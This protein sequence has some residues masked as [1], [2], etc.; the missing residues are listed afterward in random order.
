MIF[1]RGI[2]ERVMPGAAAAALE[3]LFMSRRAWPIYRGEA[4]LPCLEGEVEVRFDRWGVPHVRAQSLADLMRAQGYLVAQE[5]MVQLEMLRRAARGTLAEIVGE[6]AAHHDLF[7]RT[8]GLT[9][10]ARSVAAKIPQRSLLCLRCYSEGVNAYLA[11]FAEG[12]AAS[13]AALL[14]KLLSPWT[15]EDSLLCHLLFAWNAEATWME[16]LVKGRAMRRL[17][18][19]ATLALYPPGPSGERGER[20]PDISGRDDLPPEGCERDFFSGDEDRPA[21]WTPA[22]QARAS[23]CNGIV[24][25]GSRTE[26]GSPLLANDLHLPHAEPTFFFLLHLSC[27]EVPFDAAG[28]ALPGVP[29]IYVGRNRRI[30]WGTVAMSCPAMDVCVERLD[31]KGKGLYLAEGIWKKLERRNE[32]IKVF[33]RRVHNATVELTERG[34]LVAVDGTIGISLRWIDHA[35]EGTDAVGSLLDLNMAEDWEGFRRAL[36]GY[37]GPAS[38]FLYADAEGR[39][40]Y[41]AAGTV[42]LREGYDGS[43][44]LPGWEG[45]Y[46]WNGRLPYDDM[47]YTPQVPGGA[48]VATDGR[49]EVAPCPEGADMTDA[50]RRR[51]RIWELLGDARAVSVEDLAR[52]LADR[53]HSGGD[54]IRREILRAAREREE[55]GA[56]ARQALT[57]L[58]EW[59][60]AAEE[61]SAAQSICHLTR[62]VL[63][64]RLLRHRLGYRLHYDYVTT[65]RAADAALEG[66]LRERK[67]WWLPPTASSFEDLV[68]QCLEEALV[69]LEVRFGSPHPQDWKWGRLHCLRIP[70]YLPL[71]A[72]LRGQLWLRDLP[73]G[74]TAESIDR[75]PHVDHPSVQLHL[76]SKRA[77]PDFVKG[78]GFGDRAGAGPVLRLIVDL[79]PGGRSWWCVDLGQSAHL[80]SPYRRNF[81]PLWIK[82]EYAPM[83][84]GEEE[85][86]RATASRLTLRPAK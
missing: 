3:A 14:S 69:R 4:S 61:E 85:I 73:R 29:G 70:R 79:S 76:R 77:F 34:P 84:M 36:R 54:F 72:F 33:P 1:V 46:G 51:A 10:K 57:L 5:R 80:R 56:A 7:M 49:C 58:E 9:E 18:R 64:E 55:L 22:L 35:E 42:P 12:R 39:V 31:G 63:S 38:F 20:T 52:I 45:R 66:I 44:P 11:R 43:L 81:L 23:G 82:G 67:D 37:P 48:L 78:E 47:P 6:R 86:A 32:E 2:A 27:H 53:Y 83:L 50:S 71:P 26:R 60:G 24:L 16:A 17:G 19:E 62:R 74:G 65:C 21:W 59:D 75:S 68:I 28:A 8:V 15:V 25:G 40:A 13:L 30:A 41:Q